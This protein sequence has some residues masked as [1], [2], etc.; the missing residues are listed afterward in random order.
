ML[1]L[2]SLELNVEEIRKRGNIKK[3]GVIGYMLSD[4]D[5]QKNEILEELR[6]V[7]YKGLEDLVYRMRLSYDEIMDILDFKYNPT[8]R[9]GYSLDPGI[10]EVVN[11]NNTSKSILTD[12]VKVSVT[13]D[14]VRLNSNLKIIQTL[15]FTDKSFSYT[16]LG[17]TQSRS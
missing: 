17:F 7:K 11:L 3:I 1:E 4:F 9:T 14:D 5:T 16:I 13:I 15:I 8:T 6:K 10:Y 12:N 2:K